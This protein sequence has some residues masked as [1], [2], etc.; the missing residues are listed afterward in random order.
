M[1]CDVEQAVIHMRVS[2]AN[3]EW[4]AAASRAAGLSSAKGLDA[5]LTEAREAGVSLRA[6][7]GQV[8]RP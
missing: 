2:L 6:V 4:L 5:I 3:K 8:I 7:T 1:L